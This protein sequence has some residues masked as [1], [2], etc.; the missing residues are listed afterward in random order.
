MMDAM[1]TMTADEVLE[2]FRSLPAEE[3][4]RVA[5]EIEAIAACDNDEFIPTPEQQADVVRA[6]KAVA[7]GDIVSGEEI[8]AMLHR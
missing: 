3:R 4:G 6:L 5:S 2:G 7:E 8:R 1:T